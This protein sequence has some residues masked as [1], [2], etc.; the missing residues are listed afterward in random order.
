MADKKTREQELLEMARRAGV[1][2]NEFGGEQEP[3]EILPE[4]P[5]DPEAMRAEMARREAA[6]GT[7]G[8]FDELS[9]L[10]GEKAVSAQADAQVRRELD[11]KSGGDARKRVAQAQSQA[12]S[13]V[14]KRDLTPRAPA[15]YN[16]RAD[17][18][19]S[20]VV[21]PSVKVAGAG[22]RPGGFQPD[23]VV[24]ETQGGIPIPEDVTTLTRQG[25]FGRQDSAATQGAAGGE[26]ARIQEIAAREKQ[27]GDRYFLDQD[28]KA[29][30]DAEAQRAS[31]LKR[32]QD[33]IAAY[34]K[35]I[36][37]PH[38]RMQQWG[39]GKKIAFVLASM[40]GGMGGAGTGRNPFL[41]SFQ[42]F[43]EMDMEK[44]REEGAQRDKKYGA[45][46]DLYSL[47]RE[48]VS[49]DA[50][51]RATMR[52][53][54]WKTFAG[55]IEQ[56][57][58]RM[59]V[60]I[61]DAKFK[62]LKAGIDEKYRDALLEQAKLAADKTTVQ[63]SI[64][65]VPPQLISLG[66]KATGLKPEEVSKR[67]GEYV[68]FREKSGQPLREAAL[69][70][71]RRALDSLPQNL[72]GKMMEYLATTRGSLS[73]AMRTMWSS[74]DPEAKK[75]LNAMATAF[76]DIAR[77]DG[78][79]TLP[80]DEIEIQKM[81]TDPGNFV[82]FYDST[83]NQYNQVE[84]DARLLLGVEG[85]QLVPILDRLRDWHRNSPGTTSRAVGADV[86]EGAMPKPAYPAAEAR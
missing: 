45:A 84:G 57:A 21:A 46:K 11:E 26:L 51:A 49:S 47:I 69:D 76:V 56:E 74:A 10:G 81:R 24:V 20:G 39:I 5:Y 67:I 23:K 8:R 86:L 60:D 50:E 16:A 52:A 65:Y 22:V 68:Q 36:E 13:E 30:A 28:S 66:A 1:D 83:A 40:L 43:A 70:Q 29:M 19:Q 78:G 42:K 34:D 73:G 9:K 63:K 77:A 38:D 44:M 53:M 72:K 31:G 58:A 32:V 4:V 7:G 27:K 6:S 15:E 17:L 41:E 3:I 48:N 71:M 14:G 12:E 62:D 64:K 35:P 2:T 80:K 61:N 25:Y 79:K 82:N 33:A 55:R 18:E 59:G 85:P 37:T 54:Y 75:A